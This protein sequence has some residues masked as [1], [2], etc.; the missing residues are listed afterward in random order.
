VQLDR[1]AKRYRL[2]QPWVVRDVSVQLA[3]GQLGRGA[4][5]GLAVLAAGLGTAVSC[6][7][8]GSPVATLCSPPAE[9][10]PAIALLST[11]STVVLALVGEVSPARRLCLR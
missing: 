6:A 7:F 4:L 1:V 5:P 10:H 2:R 9:R 8:V 3:A 11:T